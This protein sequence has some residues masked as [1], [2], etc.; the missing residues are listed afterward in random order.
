MTRSVKAALHP[1]TVGG[2]REV[3]MGRGGYSLVFPAGFPQVASFR[4]SGGFV[5]AGEELSP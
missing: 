1:P 5:S 4:A 3:W 2:W